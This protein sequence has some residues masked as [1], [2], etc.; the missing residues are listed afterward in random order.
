M[1][2]SLTIL[3]KIQFFGVGTFID[4]SQTLIEIFPLENKT[5]LDK[6]Q[7]KARLIKDLLNGMVNDFLIQLSPSKLAIL[8][9]GVGTF[10][11]A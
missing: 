10:F 1:S 11:L 3:N 6:L 9:T 8:V 7:E 2:P 5:D 4:I